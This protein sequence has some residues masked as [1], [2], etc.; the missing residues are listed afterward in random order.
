M[1][2]TNFLD[3]E[4]AQARYSREEIAELHA[5]AMQGDRQA[6]DDILMSHTH[7]ARKLTRKFITRYSRLIAESSADDD[8]FTQAAILG[9]AKA[10]DGFKPDQGAFGTYAG[11][12]IQKEMLELLRQSMPLSIERSVWEKKCVPRRHTHV[13][14]LSEGEQ[15]QMMTAVSDTRIYPAVHDDE[16]QLL[17]EAMDRLTDR[18]Y[19]VLHRHFWGRMSLSEIARIDGVSR[20]RISET[21][22]EAIAIL[23]KLM[24]DCELLEDTGEEEE[25]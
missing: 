12:F 25:R 5:Q 2:S 23:R 13:D 17:K 21:F 22:A 11:K 7:L 18:Q 15:D 8:D 16:K 20:Q 6:R 24:P 3:A 9:L 10:I 19:F 4:D 1:N 14:S